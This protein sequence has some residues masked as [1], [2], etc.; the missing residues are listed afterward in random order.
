MTLYEL[1]HPG[2]L[3]APLL[4][5]AFD[6]WVNA[7]SVGTATADH[8]AGESPA[9]ATFDPDALYDYRANRPVVDFVAGVLS[10]VTL[11]QMTL[12]LR[13]L[14]ERDVLVLSGAEPNWQWRRFAA[15]VADLALQLGVVEEI[16]IGGIPSAVPHTRPTPVLSTASQVDLIRDEGRRPPGLLR[17]PGAAVTIVEH[18]IAQRG[19]P[20][21]G[22]W[23]QVPHYIASVYH[24][25]TVVLVEEISRHGGVTIPFEGLLEESAEQLRHLDELVAADEDARQVIDQLEQISGAEDGVPSGEDLATEIERYLAETDDDGFPFTGG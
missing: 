17:V 4:I 13:H 16:S 22:F 3:R 25:A 11:P 20:T 15:A 6:G 21:V 8:L 2:P 19:L 12:R 14:D 23:A 10:S 1:E 9:V 7:G 24:P 5:V 18:G